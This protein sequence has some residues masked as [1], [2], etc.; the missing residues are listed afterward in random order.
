MG[1]ETVVFR[2]GNSLAVR[3]V[4]DCKLPRG[5]RVRE[6]REGN[7]IVLE[8][9]S[10]AWPDEFIRAAGAWTEAIPRPGREEKPRDPF[11]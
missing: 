5:Q 8:P 7:R 6:R 4:G 10:D 3:L 11:A 2:V 1:N 9:V